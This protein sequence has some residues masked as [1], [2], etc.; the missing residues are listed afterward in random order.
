MKLGYFGTPE[1]SAK[2]LKALI[3]SDLAEVLFVV[4]NPDRP[5]GRSKTPEA[6][7]VKKS[8]S[9]I[10]FRY[11]N[12][13]PLKRKRKKPFPISVLFR[14]IFM[15]FL[16]TV[17]FF[18]KKCMIDRLCLPSTYTDLCCRI[19]AEP[20]PFKPRFGKVT[21]C[22]ELRSNTLERKWTKVISF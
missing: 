21:I 14:P 16:P 6:G 10:G 1:H 18:R 17:P 13:N 9:N 4:T 20:L 8:L 12:T 2:L 7:P 3:D 19:C 15:W 11:F 5:K 22:P